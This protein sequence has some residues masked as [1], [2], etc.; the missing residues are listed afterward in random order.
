[1]TNDDFLRE[2]HHPDVPVPEGMQSVVAVTRL[3][4]L[5]DSIYNWGRRNSVW[6]MAFGLACCAIEMIATASSTLGQK[7]YS[8]TN[9][10]RSALDSHRRRDARRRRMFT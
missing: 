4:K 3:G 2:L 5:V 9:A 7:Q 8:Q 10:S 1:M 6:P